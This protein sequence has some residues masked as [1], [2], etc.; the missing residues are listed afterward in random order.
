MR[1]ER[2]GLDA[3]AL[4]G[5]PDQLGDGTAGRKRA[6]RGMHPQEDVVVINAWAKMREVV[7]Q[8]VAGGLGQR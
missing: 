4:D 3:G 6:E 7:Q 1:T 2:G 5:A 8:R